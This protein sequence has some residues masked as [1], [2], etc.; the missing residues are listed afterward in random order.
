MAIKGRVRM[1]DVLL[2]PQDK[3]LVGRKGPWCYPPEPAGRSEIRRLAE[4][5]LSTNPLHFDEEYAKKSRW[6]GIIGTPTYTIRTPY[7]GGSLALGSVRAMGPTDIAKAPRRVNGGNETEVF[8]PTYAGD[9][10]R[11][12]TRIA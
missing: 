1:A 9:T 2:T 4:A 11:Q 5:T 8:R 6:G 12:R 3:A 10:V 7:G